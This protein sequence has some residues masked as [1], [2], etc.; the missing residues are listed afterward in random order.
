MKRAEKEMAK[1]NTVIG[2]GT[3]VDGNLTTKETTRIDGQ[4]N[5]DVFSNGNII[6][7]DQG[8]VNGSITAYSVFASG[9]VVGNVMVK[10]KIDIT[11]TGS[12]I[13]DIY[14]KLLSIDE[15]AVFQGQCKMNQDGN[16][17]LKEVAEKRLQAI[18][19][20]TELGS[21]FKIAM[22]DLEI[23]GAGNLLGQKQHGHMEAVGYDLYCKMLNEAVKGLKG[24]QSFEDFNTQVDLDVDA[25]I[26]GE[27]IVNEIQKLD[28]YKRIAGIE[29]I[30]E[31]NDMK[32][33][34]LD[35]FG[36]IPK[37]VDNLLRIAMIRVNAHKLFI[38]DLQGKNQ[39]V[40]IVLDKKAQVDA[41]RIPIFMKLYGNRIKFQAKGDPTFLCTYAKTGIL[42][43]DAEQLLT[44]SEKLV[45]DMKMLLL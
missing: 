43:K 36:S 44:L 30:L 14:T 35:R 3:V 42:E 7:G 8:S 31:S 34:L 16:K 38:T 24:I 39:V 1:I 4:V 9:K 12:I 17:L 6:V 18:R 41:A 27:Y 37:S 45:E 26:P 10:D 29:T 25:Y 13:G 19:E 40:K 5:G 21:G 22:R 2:V 20:F 15:K 32:E 28:I 23:R 11:A 33:E